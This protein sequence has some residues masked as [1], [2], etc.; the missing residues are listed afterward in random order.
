VFWVFG[1][2]NE[3][4]TSDD[5]EENGASTARLFDLEPIQR[6]DGIRKYKI[7]TREYMAEG[8]DGYIAFEA[9][10]HLIDHESGNLMSTFVRKYFLGED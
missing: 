9:K 3:R 2:P 10:K 4:E 5:S 7:V 6:E 1:Y 8:N